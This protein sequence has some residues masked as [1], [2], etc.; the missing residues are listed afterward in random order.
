[1]IDSDC[2]WNVKN[3]IGVATINACSL[4]FR[5]EGSLVFVIMWGSFSKVLIK[6]S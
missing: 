1:M 6:V 4:K 3:K 2:C 5:G